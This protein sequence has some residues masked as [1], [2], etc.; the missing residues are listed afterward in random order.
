MT[1]YQHA[2]HDHF[3]RQVTDAAAR[4]LGELQTSHLM[5]L[6]VSL[7]TFGLALPFWGL[8]CLGNA[9]ARQRARRSQRRLL[10]AAEAGRIDDVD[11]RA[12]LVLGLDVKRV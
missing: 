3:R 8:I 5:W 2:T 1:S 7:L 9:Y 11:R 12:A 4:T 6:G 10:A